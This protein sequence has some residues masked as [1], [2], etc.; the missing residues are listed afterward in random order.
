[1]FWIGL[2]VGLAIWALVTWLCY[3]LNTR[4]IFKSPDEYWAG[5]KALWECADNRES[6]IQVWYDGE[7]QNAVV[8]EER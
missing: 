2:I 5:Q 4:V 8:F 6:E 1:M 7:Q 3:W